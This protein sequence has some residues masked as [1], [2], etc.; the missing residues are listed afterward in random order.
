MQNWKILS[1]SYKI[2]K[3]EI[4]S[5]LDALESYLIEETLIN[6]KKLKINR[7]IFVLKLK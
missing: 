7:I 5:T 6:I 2:K 4:F 1:Y 3:K